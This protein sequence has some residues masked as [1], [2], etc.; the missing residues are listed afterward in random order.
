MPS[1]ATAKLEIMTAHGMPVGQRHQTAAALMILCLLFLWRGI[2]A[3]FA[4]SLVQESSS[5]MILIPF[6]SLTLIYLERK[7]IFQTVQAAL[8]PGL[9]VILS[10]IALYLT[11]DRPVST[12]YLSVAALSIVLILA[13]S[14]LLCYGF[15]AAFAAA[16][17][18]GFL[19]LMVPMS[20]S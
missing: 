15:K 9:I 4:Y 5:H 6:I 20:D 3:L 11:M 8:L 1:D 7:T 10:G 13:G 12:R 19:L 14:F 17:P 16:F 2:Y 18:L